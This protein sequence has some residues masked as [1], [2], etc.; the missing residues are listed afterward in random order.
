MC[1]TVSKLDIMGMAVTGHSYLPRNVTDGISGPCHAALLRGFRLDGL[2]PP[3][4]F[5]CERKNAPGILGHG[6]GCVHMLTCSRPRGRGAG[7]PLT[8]GTPDLT[9]GSNLLSLGSQ[10][11]A[12]D[13]E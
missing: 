5:P 7:H 9:T 4:S 10:K 2:E 6:G 13:A 11:Q 1:Q 12:G 3:I 8:Q